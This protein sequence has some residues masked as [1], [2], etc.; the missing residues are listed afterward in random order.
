MERNLCVLACFLCCCLVMC[1][2]ILKGFLKSLE[3]QPKLKT[4]KVKS[5]KLGILKNKKQKQIFFQKTALK[6]QKGASTEDRTLD[7]QFT[8][9]TLY[10]WAIKAS[11]WQIYHFSLFSKINVMGSGCPRTLVNTVQT[12]E[13]NWWK[14][15]PQT[16]KLWWNGAKF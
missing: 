14:K 10:H 9:L 5:E 1:Y 8:R 11:I 3:N 16:K 6:N 15:C 12:L 7:L 13:E 2:F 4:K